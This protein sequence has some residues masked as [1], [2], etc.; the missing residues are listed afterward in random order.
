[1]EEE[2]E[3][4]VEEEQQFIEGRQKSERNRRSLHTPPRHWLEQCVCVCVCVCV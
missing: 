2:E 1:M 4:V 3:V